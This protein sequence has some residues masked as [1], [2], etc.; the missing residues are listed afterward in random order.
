MRRLIRL[1]PLRRGPVWPL[2]HDRATGLSSPEHGPGV[3]L[4]H[5]PISTGDDRVGRRRWAGCGPSPRPTPAGLG[6]GRDRRCAAADGADRAGCGSRQG[7]TGGPRGAGRAAAGRT[8]GL[9]AARR[10]LCVARASRV[11]DIRP[12]RP[13]RSA[14]SAP[15][16]RRRRRPRRDGGPSGWT[17]PVRVAT[18]GGPRDGPDRRHGNGPP[19]RGIAEPSRGR[20]TGRIGSGAARDPHGRAQN[21]KRMSR[22]CEP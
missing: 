5:R 9:R 22:I 4:G 17:A 1:G 14:A 12:G 7:R 11:C 13:S 19:L 2:P 21:G 3:G 6:I 10:D 8:G 15:T 16:G 18:A 20:G